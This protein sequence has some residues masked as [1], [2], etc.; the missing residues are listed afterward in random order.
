MESTDRFQRLVRPRPDL[1]R[2]HAEVLE[3][4]GDLVPDER[5]HDLILGILEDRRG[6]PGECGRPQPAGV[7]PGHEHAAG[8]A[9]TVEMRDEPGERP[10]KRRFPRAGR[11]EERDD[12]ARLEPKGDVRESRLGRARIAELQ[13]ADVD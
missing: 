8:E 13:P 7:H 1:G 9:A 10:Q 5:H 11:A 3:P 6:R 12:L 4:E 2:R